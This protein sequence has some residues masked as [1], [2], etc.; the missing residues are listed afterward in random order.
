[1][2]NVSMT[3]PKQMVIIT[4][5]HVWAHKTN[6]TPAIKVHVSCQESDRSYLHACGLYSY[7]SICLVFMMLPYLVVI[8]LLSQRKEKDS[9]LIYFCYIE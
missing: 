2:V 3:M 5:F 9:K 7:N 6:L 8:K 4:L 1:M